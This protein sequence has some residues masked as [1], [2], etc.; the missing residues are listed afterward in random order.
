M[1]AGAAN[2]V[3]QISG[4]G[5]AVYI[6]D[7]TFLLGLDAKEPAPGQLKR[8]FYTRPGKHGYECKNRFELSL[9]AEE[10]ADLGALI[11]KCGIKS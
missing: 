2:I 11:K 1:A 3:P 6:N 4:Q 8:V 7:A 9:N 5:G 10:P